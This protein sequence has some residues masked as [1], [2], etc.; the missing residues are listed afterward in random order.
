MIIHIFIEWA[1]SSSGGWWVWVWVWVCLHQYNHMSH[2]GGL[3]NWERTTGGGDRI[4]SCKW[5]AWLSRAIPHLR[6]VCVCVCA[7]VCVRVLHV[8][9]RACVHVPYTYAIRTHIHLCGGSIKCVLTLPNKY[10]QQVQVLLNSTYE[11]KAAG[12]HASFVQVRNLISE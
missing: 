8:C 11:L 9:V 1:T 7:W 2:I 3:E 6:G 10:N 5:I 12:G 4:C